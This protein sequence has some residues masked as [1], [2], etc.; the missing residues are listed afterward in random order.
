M[1]GLKSMQRL[2]QPQ[3]FL[4][5]K[6]NNMTDIFEN[7]SSPWLNDELNLLKDAAAKFFTSEL[8]PQ[9]ERWI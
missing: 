6:L 5:H 1:L 9:N 2:F 7:Y 8:A 3:T 4:N